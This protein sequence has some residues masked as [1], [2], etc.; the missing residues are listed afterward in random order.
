[1]PPS[2]TFKV[3]HEGQELGP[4]SLAELH[5]ALGT[6]VLCSMDWC[7]N[8][9][10]FVGI[11]TVQHVLDQAREASVQEKRERLD[12]RREPRRPVV[13]TPEDRREADEWEAAVRAEL[14]AYK[15]RLEQELVEE[16][17]L[18]EKAR[19]DF[20]AQQTRFY[21][22]RSK[23]EA[24]EAHVREDLARSHGLVSEE[25]RQLAERNQRHSGMVSEF[26]KRRRQ[27]QSEQAQEKRRLENDV[28]QLQE[29]ERSLAREKAS[30]EEQRMGMISKLNREQDHLREERQRLKDD[31][32]RLGADREQLDER[33]E[34]LAEQAAQARKRIADERAAIAEERSVLAEAERRLTAEREAFEE[35][36]RRETSRLADERQYLEGERRRLAE[37]AAWA[38][39]P[40]DDSGAPKD[41]RHYG[42]V[43]GLSGKVSF[44]EIRKAYRFAAF[45]CHP[46]K[47]QG[48]HPDF[49]A[50]ATGKLRELNEAFDYF[51]VRYDRKRG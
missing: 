9:S 35:T 28:A 1:M 25:R 33:R 32:E 51:K 20:L 24:E 2:S 21:E 37:N 19:R 31:E 15:K 8:P 16:R 17:E 44:E 39:A 7:W 23:A 18:L 50:L 42:R 12:A 4:L 14:E 38:H 36:R 13:R 43:L 10:D 49:V 30:F 11:F 5:A 6:G 3:Q 45:R 27:V 29:S 41:E 26:E 34:R 40:R 46:D 47:V 22:E 48:L